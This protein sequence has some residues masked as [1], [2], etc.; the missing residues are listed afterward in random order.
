MNAIKRFVDVL[1]ITVILLSLFTLPRIVVAAPLK[2]STDDFVITVKVYD[3]VPQ[4]IIPTYSG[5]IY[6]YDVDCD[7]DG[8]N[9][10]TGQTGDYICNY[11]SGGT[12][13][14][15][16]KG[17][18]PRIYFNNS[19]DDF[20]LLSIEQ[21]G[22]GAW[23][24]MEGAFY[25]CTNLIVNAS[26]T[27]N[28]SNVTN[29]SNMFRRAYNLQSDIG[30]WMWNTSNVK[31]M[32]S[33]FRDAHNFNQDISTWDVSNVID[34]SSMFLQA[35]AFNQDIGG[36]NTSNVT[37]MRRMFYSAKAFNQDIS[38]WDVSNV[39]DMSSMFL[40]TYAFN[41]D[42]G[43][44]NTSNVTTM[45]RMFYNA[46]AFNQ[47]IG[48]WDTS[49]VTD[50]EEMFH[51]VNIFNQDLSNWNT[52]KV[53]NMSGMFEYNSQNFNL[54]IANWDTSSV[55]DMSY[56]FYNADDFNQDISN[57][58]TSSVT[59][60]S[61]MFYWA[62]SFNQDINNWNTSNVT[63]MYRMFNGATS[64]NQNINDWDT[65]NVISMGGMFRDAY[66]FN[67]DISSWNTSNVTSMVR[68]FSKARAF[69][70]D[71]GSWDTGNVTSMQ[72]M[73]QYTDAF[74]QD[75]SD[76]NTSSVES[77]RG[78]FRSAK[79]FN[80]D[81]SGWDVSSVTNPE[82]MFCGADAFNQDIGEWDVSNMTGMR[83]MFCGN[84]LS[85]A[86]YDA[87]LIGWSGQALQTGVYFD[88]GNSTY[89]NGEI[90]RNKMIN[91]DGWTIT[92]A[93]KDCS[94]ISDPLPAP[95]IILV[96]GW[97]GLN[98]GNPDGYSCKDNDGNDN[99]G[100]DNIKPYDGTNSTT[101]ELAGWFDD[102]GY[103]VWIA[104]WDTSLKNGTPSLYE[105]ARC[106]KEQIKHVHGENPQPI[107]MV[108]HS[109][110]GLVSRSAVQYGV[111]DYVEAI[112]T[113]GT[114]HAGIYDQA[115][116]F[117]FGPISGQIAVC[118]VSQIHIHYF[119]ETTP[120]QENITY[121]FIGGSYDWS[122]LSKGKI[123]EN[124][125]AGPN[126]GLVG[127]Y[128]SIG[129]VYDEGVFQPSSWTFQSFPGQYW[130][131]EV[132]SSIFS[133]KD[134]AFAY[135]DIRTS[136]D[137]N[138]SHAF[139]CILDM[140]YGN[141]PDSNKCKKATKANL[142]TEQSTP[143]GDSTTISAVSQLEAGHLD[144]GGSISIPIQ[145][146][147]SGETYFNLSWSS[148]DFELILTRPDDQII[149]PAYAAA[150]PDEVSYEGWE[151]SAESSPSKGYHFSNTMAGEWQMNVTAT[152]AGDYW[153]YAMLSSPYALAATTDQDSYA[154]GDTATI[155]ATLKKDGAGLSGQTVTATLTNQ[156]GT[157]DTVS[158][159]DQSDGAYTN[160][161]VIPN[162][163]GY[164][165][166]SV[167]ADGD[168]AGTLFTRNTSLQVAVQPEDAAFTGT[169]TETGD[170]TNLDGLYETLDFETEINALKTG[171][172]ALSA[173]IYAGD[174]FVVHTGDFYTL[175]SGTQTVTLSFNG[176]TIRNAGLDGPYRVTNLMLI[177]DRY[178][179]AN[180]F[181]G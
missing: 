83:S 179:A 47:D 43:G 49:N 168:D 164:L 177:S 175:A 133:G 37:T 2:A 57:W 132:H 93:G 155:T 25:G 51:G 29:M 35:Y 21:W 113:I 136:E 19:G 12:Y 107:I 137:N 135:Y 103:D 64:F 30:N 124:L 147:T 149:D 88:G 108:A 38:T 31:D 23:T 66:I 141:N 87:L 58:N 97:Q 9:E 63:N 140:M 105:N 85:T 156:D 126:D 143:T 14:I 48:N 26:D 123:I 74:N 153:A 167:D 106:I 166:I 71:I 54:G 169:Y 42:I 53:T 68:M 22:T 91:G 119:N 117:L 98:M 60:M 78:M 8:I 99:D 142:S 7:S 61:Y 95:P 75:I 144:D 129:W 151:G 163:P 5:E 10:I 114:P 102:Q 40:Q 128:S 100:N 158:L 80:Q 62:E 45:M 90:A 27:P 65:S 109:M 148:G 178:R 134:D 176:T 32:S 125:G 96:H 116:S 52:S 172:Y 152:S 112:Y 180:R 104:H 157:V 79:K 4:F 33:T 131:D 24:S 44:W 50:M 130:T 120:N 17:T 146:D 28:L 1:F 36:W 82:F 55:T 115:I 20:Q 101:G 15:R 46:K 118:Q 39:I 41:Q 150:N 162:S 94:S 181:C 67:Q 122:W 173:D 18:F 34:M 174:Q 3:S 89:C 165:R 76:W 170:D 92:D 127:K 171:D 121:N 138:W 161:Y 110:G 81:I 160:T 13:S 86:N 16:I 11:P 154:M 77:M 59:N 111:G 73:F 70:Q 139:Q 72:G 56:M 69:N 145:V 6:N 84:S 159:I